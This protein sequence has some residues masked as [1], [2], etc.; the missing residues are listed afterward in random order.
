M[1]ST[2]KFI[3]ANI[4]LERWSNPKA[5]LLIE[6]LDREKYCTSVLVLAEVYHKLKKKNIEY[7]FEYIRNIMGA[8]KVYD[9]TQDDLFTAIKQDLDININDRIHI[10]TMKRN[11][12]NI[13]LS[14][15]K[16]FDN[17][18]TIIREEI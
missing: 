4:L 10:A 18:K 11:N 13:I 12:T 16:D 1:I 2:I 8:I 9:I 15:D 3:D 14:F 17:D 7:S 5:K 6:N